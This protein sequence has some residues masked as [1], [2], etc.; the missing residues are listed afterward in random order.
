MRSCGQ[1]RHMRNDEQQH[2]RIL[3]V[4]AIYRFETSSKIMRGWVYKSIAS[5]SALLDADDG[6]LSLVSLRALWSGVCHM[7]Q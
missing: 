3:R 7:L 4:S 1:V 6:A 5:Y 2:R